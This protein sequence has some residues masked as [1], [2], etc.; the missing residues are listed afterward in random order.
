MNANNSDYVTHSDLQWCLTVL[1]EIQEILK[2]NPIG[3]DDIKSVE[4]LV[5]QGL[6]CKKE[7]E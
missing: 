3:L 6:K 2:R 5:K 7:E 1:E 4:W